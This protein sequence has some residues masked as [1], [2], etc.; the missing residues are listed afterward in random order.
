M[1]TYNGV[2]LGLIEE[3]QTVAAGNDLQ[4]NAYP[5]VNGVEVLNLGSRG[6]TSL[7]RGAMSAINVAALDA[8]FA[9][10]RAMQASGATATFVDAY[11]TIW[12]DVILKSFR[13]TGPRKLLANNDG[14]IQ[15][16][17]AEFF[18]LS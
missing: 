18:H 11:G 5:G 10:F 12:F 14:V 9:L 16:Y 3:P 6:G 2:D 15:R 8:T 7:Y 1:A 13:P 17:E 4:V